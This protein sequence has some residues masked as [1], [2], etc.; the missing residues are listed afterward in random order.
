MNNL[1]V[2]F[3]NPQPVSAPDV[4]M[5]TEF[6]PLVPGLSGGVLLTPERQDDSNPFAADGTGP[7]L[8]L[9]LRFE[10]L[11]DLEAALRPAG[12]LAPLARPEALPSL[13]GASVRHQA[14]VGRSFVVPEPAEAGRDEAA[15][16]F[17]VTYPGTTADLDVW[18]D[19]YDANHPPIMVRFPG[20][21]Q[22]E[23]YRP[24]AWE[25][26]MPWARDDA[27]QRNKVVFD[28]LEAL[29]AALNSPVMSEM[30][31]DSAT[32][33]EFSP[34]ATHVPMLTRVLRAG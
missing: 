18:L 24:I 23:T 19:H 34:K 6:L 11:A 4:A 3:D 20:V 29:V 9:Q 12:A 15:L 33:P 16:T 28:S 32:F 14:M 13:A 21:R 26:A 17:L 7:A 1:F 10:I 22:V 30:R 2:L 27:M 5:L 31:A 8:V 25:S